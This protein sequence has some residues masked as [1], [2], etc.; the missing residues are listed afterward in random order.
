MKRLFNKSFLVVAVFTAFGL[1]SCGDD[2]ESPITPN[3]GQLSGGP[4]TFVVDG[5]EDNVSGIT[6]DDSNVAGTNSSYIVTDDA[7]NILG[8]PST[9]EALEGENFDD[10]GEGVCLIWYLRYEN[11]LQ[12]LEVGMNADNLSGSFDLSNS[13][14]VDRVAL[15]GASLT[16]GPFAFVVDSTPD[17]VSGITVDDSNINGMNTTFI[18]TD[19]NG[20]ILGLPG[21]L[22]DLEGVDFNAAGGGTCFIYHLTYQD[23]L[24]N[25]SMGMNIS[26]LDMSASTISNAITVYRIDAPTLSGG[27][28]TFTVD[29]GMDDNLATDAIQVEGG[30]SFNNM[31][32]WVVTNVVGEILGLPEE[33]TAVNFDGAGEGACFVWYITFGSDLTGLEMGNNVDDLMGT[34]ELSNSVRV[35][36]VIA[37]VISGGP[38]NFI[39]DMTA[40]IIPMGAISIENGG[41]DLGLSGWVVTDE[42]GSILGLP[43]TFTAPDF[44]AAGSGVCLVWYITYEDG[45]TGLETGMNANNLEGVFALSNP[46]TVNRLDAPTLS[47]GPFTFKVGDGTA[48]NITEGAIT[49]DGGFSVNDQSS[50][51]VTDENGNILGLPDS[52]TDVNF[53]GTDPGVCLIWY[54]TFAE[55]LTGLE[56]GNN[57]SG[58]DGAVYELSNSIEVIREE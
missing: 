44:N 33:F 13:I 48:D 25:L 23:D 46:V 34:Y 49:E 6:L 8:L 47:G 58:L 15:M 12:G 32:S 7:G 56:V 55:G 29:D 16:G 9:L 52:F 5:V 37:P 43:P 28:F 18:V 22:T 24:A 19:E 20:S 39:V 10:A 4:F 17:N 54:L 53:D 30:F 27:P 57:V 35:N 51:V 36:R 45:L 41:T 1:V 2:D 40:D 21:S 26:N 31:S 3:A 14:T 11:G 42:Q 50:W 38:F